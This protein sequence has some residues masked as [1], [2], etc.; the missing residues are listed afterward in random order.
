[1]TADLAAGSE[2]SYREMDEPLFTDDG[3]D[4]FESRD[5]QFHKL[6]L[7]WTP[8]ERVA[9]NSQLSYDRYTSENGIATEFDNLPK[10]VR[11]VSL[12]V[13]ITYFSKSGWFSGITG[14]FVDQD[15]KRSGTATQ[16]DGDDSFTVVD[17]VIGYR[18]GKRLGVAS[19]G[20]SNIFD[21]DFKYQDD[22]YREFRDE[23][24]IGPYFPD[25][26]VMGRLTL[27]Y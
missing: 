13:G 19:L 24:S 17:G 21:K 11:T 15:V 5:E 7:Y 2:F 8:S 3:G 10:K 25:R 4:R 14:S 6:Y 1:M 27:N 12:P 23:P 20:V 16:A 9:V 26:T 18:F 22:S